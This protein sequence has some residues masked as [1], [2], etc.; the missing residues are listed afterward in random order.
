MMPRAR[1]VVAETAE[2]VE[3]DT[4]ICVHCGKGGTVLMPKSVWTAWDNGNGPFIQRL[5]PAG[6]A[7]DREQLI[8]G[9]HDACF[10]VLFP[11]DEDDQEFTAMFP[12]TEQQ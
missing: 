8:S 5:W 6:S 2:F 7:G 1:R 10:N 3:V 9:T 4:G 12:R 11:E